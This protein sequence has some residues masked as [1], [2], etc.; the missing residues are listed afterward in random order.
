MQLRG[1]A[2]QRDV[3]R[4]VRLDIR[5]DPLRIGL[6]GRGRKGAFCLRLQGNFMDE[7]QQLGEGNEKPVM[8]ERIAGGIEQA[9]PLQQRL[10]P[11]LIGSLQRETDVVALFERL[12]N[13]ALDEWRPQQLAGKRRIEVDDRPDVV[14]LRIHFRIMQRRAV[15]KNQIPGLQI[16]DFVSDQIGAFA[17]VE[18]IDFVIQMGMEGGRYSRSIMKRFNRKLEL[19]A[20]RHF[21]TA[22]Y[23]ESFLLT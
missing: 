21:W 3:F 14:D 18:I 2:V 12:Q 6:L 15:E 23:V 22:P 5:D 10:Q 17:A 13:V 16:N 9:E 8:R 20:Q 7:Q 1:H 19:L 11:F 4:E